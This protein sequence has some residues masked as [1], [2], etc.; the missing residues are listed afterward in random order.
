[1][2]WFADVSAEYSRLSRVAEIFIAGTR[3]AESS[4]NHAEAGRASG[5]RNLHGS[6]T[7]SA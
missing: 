7:I 6:K 3:T 2:K 1:M 5:T 4:F